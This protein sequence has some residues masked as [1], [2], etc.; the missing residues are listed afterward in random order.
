MAADDGLVRQT[1]KVSVVVAALTLLTYVFALEFPLVLLLY[2]GALFGVFLRALSAPIQE[3]TGRSPGFALGIVLLLLVGLFTAAGFLAGPSLAEQAADLRDRLPQ[4][5]SEIEQK[6]RGTRIGG[7][8][9]ERLSSPEQVLSGGATGEDMVRNAARV[10]SRV[11][12]GLGAVLVV[13]FTGVF[14]AADP[15]AYRK[16]FLRLVPPARRERVAD[17]LDDVAHTLRWWL[18]SRGISMAIVGVLVFA[19][20]LALGI[21][22]AFV[23]GVIAGLLDFIPYVGPLIAAI[24]G[25][26]IAM[27]QSPA[28]AL[29]VAGL[30]AAVQVVESYIVQPIV[31]RRTVQLLPAIALAFQVLLAA[32]GGLLGAAL[33]SPILAAIVV[34]VHRFYVEDSLGEPVPH[35]RRE[36]DKS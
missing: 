24:P 16:G 6:I 26:L 20:L 10:L 27:V 29:K 19:G 4:A 11:A 8:L 1:V 14:L 33:A 15:R 36:Q 12:G 28:D 5:A 35:P 32:V 21:P 9:L 7:R 17:V 2:G 34:L 25:V 3:R 18:I 31:E 23:L 22:L 13:L 30:Y